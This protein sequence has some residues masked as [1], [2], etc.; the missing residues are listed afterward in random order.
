V[1]VDRDGWGA[2]PPSRLYG[3]L[4]VSKVRGVQMHHNGPAMGLLGASHDVCP[5]RVRGLQRFHM[6]T[7]GW[8]D[9]AYSYYLCPHGVLF[10]CRGLRWP[11]F[12][13]GSDQVPPYDGPDS[14]WISVMSM[15]GYTPPDPA[16]E[17]APTVDMYGAME[18]LRRYLA[19][20]GV[21]GRRVTPHGD[22]LD[23]VPD[24]AGA[25]KRKVCPGVHWR[26]WCEAVDGTDPATVS[27]PAGPTVER[28]DMVIVKAPS[29]AAFMAVGA[30][31][32]PVSLT[33]DDIPGWREQGVPVVDAP[34]QD[35]YDAMF[36]AATGSG[37]GP[38]A[39]FSNGSFTGKFEVSS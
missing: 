11:Q 7:L 9:G 33:G 24:P 2:R 13:G 5:R 29:G 25:R 12:A 22:G 17:E 31:A 37:G 4:N 15:T 36:D 20:H 10:E 14:Q 23:D 21:G 39:V 18:W 26:A 32:L 35:G 19:D 1:I 8:S 34:T 6:D 3:T 27:Q 16:T 38:Q 30:G 28:F